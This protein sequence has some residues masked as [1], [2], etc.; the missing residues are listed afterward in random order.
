MENK[1][2]ASFEKVQNIPYRLCNYFPEEINEN[3]PFGSCLHKSDL[4][5]RL[6]SKEVYHSRYGVVAFDLLD[7]PIPKNIL[8]ILN[9]SGTIRNHRFVEVF[10]NSR[11]IRIDPTW[12]ICLKQIGFPVT[13]KWDGLSDT[14]LVSTGRLDLR[15][16]DE[17]FERHPYDFNER[18][19]FYHAFNQWIDETYTTLKFRT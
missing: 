7:L 19:I 15:S 12:P 11:W 8:G 9:K 3:L 6:I 5:F 4:L 18:R 1:L 10:L 13:E 17:T 2:I 16:A 14:V